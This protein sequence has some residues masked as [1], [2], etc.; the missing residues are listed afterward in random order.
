M[1]DQ[2]EVQDVQTLLA[3]FEVE[4]AP[5]LAEI[6]GVIKYCPTPDGKGVHMVLNTQNGPVT[7]IYMPDTP[8]TDRQ[9]LA[10]DNVEAILVQLDRGSAA[11]I[12]AGGQ[13]VSDYYAIIQDSI[14][15][16]G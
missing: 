12:G 9:M 11:I 16:A 7:V 4:A 1:A 5:T 6:V 3:G 8:V 13:Q 2:A 15:P 10:F 14:V